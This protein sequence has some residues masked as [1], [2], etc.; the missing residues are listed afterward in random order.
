MTSLVTAEL[1]GTKENPHPDGFIESISLEERKK[2]KG[3]W[4]IYKNGLR[5]ISPPGLLIKPRDQL[6][7]F[8]GYTQSGF[9]L[10]VNIEP[11]SLMI[12]SN[13]RTIFV[14][15]KQDISRVLRKFS[16]EV[17]IYFPLSSFLSECAIE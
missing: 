15:E 14:S 5:R 2:Y 16:L 3:Y 1:L 7:V 4:V 13:T 17:F 11:L 12:G 6:N 8:Y 10:N 9:K